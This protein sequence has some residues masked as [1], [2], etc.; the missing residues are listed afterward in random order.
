[1]E[2]YE[3]VFGKISIPGTQLEDILYFDYQALQ[4]LDFSA[5]EIDF[6]FREVLWLGEIVQK[7]QMFL[8]YLR[9][10]PIFPVL[11][12]PSPVAVFISL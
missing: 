5:F 9:P 3:Q 12:I 10:A 6:I 8:T 7:I 4:N 11:S 1:M 2:S